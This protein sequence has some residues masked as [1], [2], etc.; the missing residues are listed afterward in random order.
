MATAM[1]RLKEVGGEAAVEVMEEIKKSSERKIDSQIGEF[2]DKWDKLFNQRMIYA[3]GAIIAVAALTIVTA[4]YTATKEVNQSVITLQDKILSS[5]ETIR[6]SED[7]LIAS[8]KALTDA[9]DSLT[10][11]TREVG[12]ALKELDEAKTALKT[13]AIEMNRS[14]QELRKLQARQESSVRTKP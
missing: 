6:K 12:N 9:T 4:L 14:T 2:K 5:Q 7:Q 10:S 8:K 1:E 11:K 3:L 13:A